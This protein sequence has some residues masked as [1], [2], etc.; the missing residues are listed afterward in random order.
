MDDTMK[1]NLDL[2]IIGKFETIDYAGF[3]K[4]PIDRLDMYRELVQ[5]RMVY[6]DGGFHHFL[7]IFNKAKFGRYYEQSSY[8]ERRGMYNIWNL[9]SLNPALAVTPML[10]NGLN[11]R[12]INNLDSEFDIFIELAQSMK[13]PLIAISTTFL[14]SWGVIGKLIKKIREKVD[15]PTFIIGGAFIN[16]QV[17]INGGA[18]HLEK[19]LRKYGISYAI[20]SYNSEV[21]LYNLVS[22]IESKDFSKVNNLIFFEDDKVTFTKEQWNSPYILENDIPPWDKIDLPE[23]NKTI[24][25]RSSSGC[26]F[27]CSFCTY[28]VQSKGFHPAEMDYLKAQLEIIKHMK[29]DNLIFIDDTPNFPVQRFK[30][31]LKLLQQYD[32]R[33]FAFIRAQYIDDEI[34]RMMKES[35]CDGV[36]LGIESADNQIL[37]YMK[38][39]ANNKIYMQGVEYLKRYDITTFAAFII[40]FPGETSETIQTN[41]DFIKQSGID[42]YSLKEFWYAPNAPIAKKA[43]KFGLEGQG[44]KWK[45]NTMTSQEASSIKLEIFNDV[46]ESVYLD[47]DSGLWYLAYL[48]DQN[49]GW[50]TIEKSQRLIVEMLRRDNQN[51]YNQKQDLL[52]KFATTIKH[53]KPQQKLQPKKPQQKL[54]PKKP[55]QKLQPINM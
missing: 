24:Q 54:Q 43:E 6:Q 55:Q 45:H 33:W 23:N 41:I 11:V 12:I 2:I 27:K 35:G 26:A 36:Y 3:S 32:F 48:R 25:L 38:K 53:K 30:A 29:I 22:N 51:K 44:N 40:G 4:L 18:A 42:Y 19:P 39:A 28:P 1:G 46:N 31:M 16:D 50:N 5:L 49:Y 9:P 47:S 8:T 52:D 13:R 34:A 10:N 20:H 15:N 17:A 21:D 37:K 7:D 14:L